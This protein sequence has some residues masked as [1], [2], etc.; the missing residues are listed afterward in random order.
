[1]MLIL[2]NRGIQVKLDVIFIDNIYT[3]ANE[4]D[5]SMKFMII[6]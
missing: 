2:W 6:I 4:M 3:M 1:M 5:E